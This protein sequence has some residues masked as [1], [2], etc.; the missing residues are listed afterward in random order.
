MSTRKTGSA[1]RKA[2]WGPKVLL[3]VMLL[4][5]GLGTATAHA[6]QP[7]PQ[8]TAAQEGFVPVDKLPAQQQE[9]IPAARL[10]GIA[11]GFVWLMLLGYL[12]SIW[13]RLSKV[14]RDLASV[15]RRVSSGGRSA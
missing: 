1:R 6:Q 14:E 3:G 12:W 7:P 8:P 13:N 4:V 15:S 11:Y 9:T 10:V 5:I 2:V